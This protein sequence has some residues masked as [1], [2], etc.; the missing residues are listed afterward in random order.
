MWISLF[1][2]YKKTVFS[3]VYDLDKARNILNWGPKY[4]YDEW[5]NDCQKQD[6]NFEEEKKQHQQKKSILNKILKIF[7]K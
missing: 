5:F 7:K 4:N 2:S 1:H 3:G 6:L